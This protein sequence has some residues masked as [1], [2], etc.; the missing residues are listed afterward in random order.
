[1]KLTLTVFI[2]LTQGLNLV[3]F[4]QLHELK[5]TKPN[6]NEIEHYQLTYN[7]NQYN[8][9]H[10]GFNKNRKSRLAMGQQEHRM[11]KKSVSSLK[12]IF[13]G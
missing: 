4:L 1:M 13:L 11:G 8:V 7:Y 9:I 5:V 3:G 12:H 6:F 10:I 2:N